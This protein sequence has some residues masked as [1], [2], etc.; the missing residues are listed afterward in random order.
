MFLISSVKFLSPLYLSLLSKDDS[1]TLAIFA[2]SPV[3]VSLLF[4]CI[5][6]LLII[7]WKKKHLVRVRNGIALVCF[8]LWLLSGRVI[9]VYHDG[10]I[11]T[12]WFCFRT[13]Q[14]IVCNYN[15]QE[16]CENTL[17]KTEVVEKSLWR[18]EVRNKYGTNT[19]FLG[20]FCWR[21]GIK[22]L[23]SGYPDGDLTI[24]FKL[25]R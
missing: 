23:K 14:I 16:D 3:W 21:E 9:G 1:H 22:V 2:D 25:H 12:G 15:E 8:F 18:A 5:L 17:F 19:V 4:V 7:F 13:E 6:I 10:K 20:P 24:Y 11:I